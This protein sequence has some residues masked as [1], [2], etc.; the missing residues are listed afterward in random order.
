[1][2]VWKQ[3]KELSEQEG[4]E[5]A[6]ERGE[7]KILGR[8]REA[9]PLAEAQQ[10]SGGRCSDASLGGR[11]LHA[12]RAPRKAAPAKAKYLS[13]APQT[14]C[15]E[16]CPRPGLSSPPLMSQSA[17]QEIPKYGSLSPP[18]P[19]PLFPSRRHDVEGM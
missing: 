15:V 2:L 19:T 18:P 1:M 10:Q 5:G 8:R 11:P 3:P 14:T 9:N 17:P 6:P 4:K 16:C 12:N 7:R 13:R